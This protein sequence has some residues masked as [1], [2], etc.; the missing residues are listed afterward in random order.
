MYDERR[1]KVLPD[2]GISLIIISYSD[3]E[4]DKQKRIKRD[5][6]SDLKIVKEKL[7]RFLSEPENTK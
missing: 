5:R 6:T 3:F 1:Q 4:Y 2:Y 7:D